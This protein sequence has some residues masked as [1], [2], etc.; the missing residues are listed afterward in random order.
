CVR[1]SGLPFRNSGGILSGG[2]RG[3]VHPAATM[4]TVKINIFGVNRVVKLLKSQDLHSLK[5]FRRS[6]I[7]NGKILER[8][9]AELIAH[10]LAADGAYLGQIN[11]L[12]NTLFPEPTSVVGAHRF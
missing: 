9:P 8:S 1:S 11:G 7:L 10:A 4:Q 5:K 6:L 3:G 2:C 12:R